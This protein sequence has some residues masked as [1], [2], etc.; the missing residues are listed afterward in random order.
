MR[1]ADPRKYVWGIAARYP[2]SFGLDTKLYTAVAHLC[3]DAGKERTNN[4]LLLVNSRS[5]A[6]TIASCVRL[7]SIKGIV[8]ES[9]TRE[10]CLAKLRRGAQG[11]RAFADCDVDHPSG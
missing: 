6:L 8:R 10:N 11:G 9:E 2:R 1:T 4:P 5:D 7:R 3:S